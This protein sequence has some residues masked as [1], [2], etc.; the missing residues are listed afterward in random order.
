MGPGKLA[1][2]ASLPAPLIGPAPAGCLPRPHIILHVTLSSVPHSPPQ[3]QRETRPSML[4]TIWTRNLEALKWPAMVNDNSDLSMIATRS[5][6]AAGGGSA[7]K[8]KPKAGKAAEGVVPSDAA[9]ENEDVHD[10]EG[11]KDHV[12]D[13]E[14]D[15]EEEEEDSDSDDDVDK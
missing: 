5:Q 11:S 9:A 7:Q 14:Q 10:G 8:G 15:E 1:P 12:D 4:G 6:S 13:E 2:N 3:A